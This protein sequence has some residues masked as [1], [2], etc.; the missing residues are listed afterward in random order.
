MGY[1]RRLAGLYCVPTFLST[2][3]V[4]GRL[5]GPQE[6]DLVALARIIV[7]PYIHSSLRIGFTNR[8]VVSLG[9]LQLLAWYDVS[10]GMWIRNGNPH[11]LSRT[12]WPIHVEIVFVFS[13]NYF[14]ADLAFTLR[15]RHARKTPFG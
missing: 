4:H 13:C 9:G 6:V 14:L 1:H 8:V 12:P 10:N 3:F 11:S 7:V 5:D 2:V 15:R